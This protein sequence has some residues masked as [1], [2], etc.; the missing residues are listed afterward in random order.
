MKGVALH[1]GSCA[2]RHG[3]S[4]PV[5]L[6]WSNAPFAQWFVG[7]T[8]NASVNCV[9]RHVAAGRGDKVAIHFEGEPGDARSI[10]YGELAVLVAMHVPDDVLRSAVRF[11]FSP[12]LGDE[13]ITEA[14][15]RIAA[16]VNRLRHSSS[17]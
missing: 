12:L 2:R 16:V 8:L 17:D 3:K 11:S 1:L 15:R 10:T 9:D 5:T 13:E 4:R 6:D 14:A 7:G